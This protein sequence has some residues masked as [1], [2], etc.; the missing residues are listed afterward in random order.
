MNLKVNVNAAH[1]L[2]A[3]LLESYPLSKIYPFEI[4]KT[5]S[6]YLT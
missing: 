4:C 3:A 6:I 2:T 1:A 5:I